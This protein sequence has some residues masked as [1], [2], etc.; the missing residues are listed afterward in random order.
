MWTGCFAKL[1]ELEKKLSVVKDT[2]LLEKACNVI[3]FLIFPLY[4]QIEVVSAGMN[5][6]CTVS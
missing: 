5:T 6:I 4:K 3:S 2:Q 1:L